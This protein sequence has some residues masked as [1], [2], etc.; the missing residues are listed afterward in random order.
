[1]SKKQKTTVFACFMALVFILIG[2]V[3]VFGQTPTPV[4]QATAPVAKEI[5]IDQQVLELRILSLQQQMVLESYKMRDAKC[6]EFDANI[7]EMKKRAE[8]D[9]VKLKALQEKSKK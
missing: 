6:F 8:A 7:K 1:M 9:T 3:L 4:P 2:T 5:P